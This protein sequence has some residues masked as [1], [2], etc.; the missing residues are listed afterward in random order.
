MSS[1][2]VTGASPDNK[3]RV[4]MVRVAVSR[5]GGGGVTSLYKDE[6]EGSLMQRYI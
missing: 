3:G 2:S 4:E 5:G 1:S 6:R